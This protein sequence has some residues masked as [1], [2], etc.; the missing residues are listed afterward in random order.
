MTLSP[1]DEVTVEAE[2]GGE[3]DLWSS[4]ELR[5]SIL[6]PCEAS[7]ELGDSGTF[8]ELKEIT[9]IGKTVAVSVNGH[10]FIRGRI[11]MRNSPL[12][13]GQ[14]SQLRFVVRTR[15]ADAA[16]QSA[17]PRVRVKNQSIKDFVLACYEQLGM[18]ESDFLFD[19]ETARDLMSGAKT[20]GG[21]AQPDLEPLKEDQAKI[22]PPETVREAVERHLRRHGLM[23]RDGPDGRIVIFRPDEDQ[24][25]RYFF[26]LLRQPNSQ[27]NNVKRVE[28]SQDFTEAPS[29]LSVY[30]VGGKTEFTKAKVSFRALNADVDQHFFRPIIIV[31]EG[32]KTKELAERRALREN[33]QRRRRLDTL[34]IAVDGL[35]YREGEGPGVTFVPDSVCDV[36][37]E[38]V[39]GAIGNYY[40]EEVVLRRAVGEADTAQLTATA[41]GTWVL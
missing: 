21:K 31:D 28:R 6:N 9:Q 13:A 39:G 30:G 33:A 29:S 10:P 37:A 19:A 38:T 23:Q 4:F 7:F 2:D 15:L 24:E 12:D 18:G 14:S 8:D 35:S 11:H 5:A 20:K 36:I 40:V 27:D 3:F 17:D 26:R 16:V 34:S 32:V 1:T 22:Q 25:P 41:P